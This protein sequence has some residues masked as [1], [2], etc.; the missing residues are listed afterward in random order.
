MKKNIVAVIS[1][2]IVGWICKVFLFSLPYKFTLHPDTQHIFGTIGDWMAGVA[3]REVGN[4]FANIGPF[5][6]GGFELLTSSVLLV[7]A[8]LWVLSKADIGK[9]A[10]CRATYH[11]IGGLMASIVMAG[12]GFFH[13]F[14]PFGI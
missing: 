2:M 8:V 3:G 7:P 9:D 5:A 13:L 1:W 4:L 11:K 6:V 14:T 10:G 12:A